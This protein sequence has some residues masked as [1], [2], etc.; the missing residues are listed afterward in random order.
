LSNAVS[1]AHAEVLLK[2]RV[3][4]VENPGPDDALRPD[5]IEQPVAGSGQLLIEVG[6]AAPTPG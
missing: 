6:A 5:S 3:I 2:M 1:F 4:E